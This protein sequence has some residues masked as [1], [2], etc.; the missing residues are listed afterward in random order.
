MGG[1]VSSVATATATNSA[2]LI[3]HHGELREYPPPVTVSQV[4]LLESSTATSPT[5]FVCNSDSL[6]YDDYIPAMNADDE[7]EPG[8]IY[9]IVDASKLR[10]RLTASD[11]AALAVKAS[12]A[13]QHHSRKT[14][15]H[16]RNHRSRISPVLEG[17]RR[18]EVGAMRK[19]SMERPAGSGSVRKLQR[20]SS[21]RARKAARSFRLRLTTIYEGS[22]L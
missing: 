6:Y 4:L 8:Q 5:C 18:D 9:F 10:Y 15:R 3:S 13:L 14:G 21:Q 19:T 16:H 22:V 12:I 20:Y 2:L 17:N 1:C 11:M 7:L